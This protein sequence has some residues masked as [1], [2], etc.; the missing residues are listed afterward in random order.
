MYELVGMRDV[1]FTGSDGKQVR[2]MHLFFT[3]KD[4]NVQGLATDK[5]FVSYERFQKLSFVPELGGKCELRYNKYG[6][7]ADIVPV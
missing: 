7:V 4:A 1:D 2:G 5:V 3:Y 6:R